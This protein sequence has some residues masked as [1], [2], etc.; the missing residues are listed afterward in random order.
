MTA[1]KVKVTLWKGN[2]NDRSKS[3]TTWVPENYTFS[4]LLEDTIMR[5]NLK[6]NKNNLHLTK[7]NGEP[8]SLKDLVLNSLQNATSFHVYLCVGRSNNNS[9]SSTNNNT[10]HGSGM[11]TSSF[12]PSSSSFRAVVPGQFRSKPKRCGYDSKQSDYTIERTPS[13]KGWHSRSS[14]ST[15]LTPSPT[16]QPSPP[17]IVPEHSLGQA[18]ELWSIFVSYSVKSS[19]DD[20]YMQERPFKIFCRDCG[21]NVLPA[22]VVVRD[23]EAAV[24][25]RRHTNGSHKMSF[26]QFLD[27][28]ADLSQRVHPG[29]GTMLDDHLPHIV[30]GVFLV[31]Y[32]L[33]RAERIRWGPSDLEWS[34]RC[35]H[36]RSDESHSLILQIAMT[37]HPIFHFYVQRERTFVFKDRRKTRINRTSGGYKD[38]ERVSSRSNNTKR[39]RL[40][41]VIGRRNDDQ[42]CNSRGDSQFTYTKSEV[43][44]KTNLESF[45]DNT[46][47]L[48]SFRH[49]ASDFGLL[50]FE[51]G[52]REFNVLF[53]MCCSDRGRALGQRTISALECLVDDEKKL[54]SNH[55]RINRTNQVLKGKQLYN[56]N[57]LKSGFIRSSFSS[58]WGKK[59]KRKENKSTA[60]SLRYTS[61]GSPA[62]TLSSTNIPLIMS[63][64]SFPSFVQAI[65]FLGFSGFQTRFARGMPRLSSMTVESDT[66]GHL[67]IKQTLNHIAQSSRATLLTRSNQIRTPHLARRTIEYVTRLKNCA[68]ALWNHVEKMIRKDGNI[69]NYLE[70]Y[71]TA[72]ENY[73]INS[74]NLEDRRTAGSYR[75]QW[76]IRKEKIGREINHIGKNR[77]DGCNFNGGYDS[78]MNIRSGS[79][80]SGYGGSNIVIIQ[81]RNKSSKSS[82]SSSLRSKMVDMGTNNEW[83]PVLSHYHSRTGCHRVY[84]A[85]RSVYEEHQKII[86]Y[87]QEAEASMLLELEKAKKEEND[88][89]EREENDARRA[90]LT[91][92]S[93]SGKFRP[94]TPVPNVPPS[95][96]CVMA[97]RLFIEKQARGIVNTPDCLNQL[98]RLDR[99]DRLLRAKEM[100]L[101]A[102]SNTHH[103]STT[104]AIHQHPPENING[105]PSPL[106]PSEFGELPLPKYIDRQQ[107]EYITR[108]SRGLVSCTHYFLK[109]INL[110]FLINK[111]FVF[112]NF[113]ALFHFYNL[114][115]FNLILQRC[116]M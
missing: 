97:D 61:L 38:D 34:T 105:P 114:I 77:D 16:S 19:G 109:F 20:L 106:L 22:A 41:K 65:F 71:F 80:R 89:K 47:D 3:F 72:E 86:I 62:T 31:K 27:A 91:S 13:P 112:S 10:S 115:F 81:T 98:D 96:L 78:T 68:T 21:L 59:S 100:Y 116:Q 36:L 48:S 14:A 99:F 9:T 15:S 49:F 69:V 18:D 1:K 42:R 40:N 8:Y 111:F 33:V 29:Q 84:D 107:C 12:S 87:E 45:D 75:K 43:E 113:I 58:I 11:S 24:V 93:L 56:I 74:S 66:A 46:M 63:S 55:G 51:S 92:A 94:V 108:W 53:A 85:I 23:E 7:N 39:S 95:Q 76:S 35:S 2:E 70:R 26:E 6:S 25:Y 88:R 28:L 32:V 103:T 82:G 30:L 50:D 104:Y 83:Q 54:R 52:M 110:L 60:S 5:W 44:K 37:L 67:V 57:A 64:M 17:N 4:N 102:I 79:G 90:L 73:N 101:Q